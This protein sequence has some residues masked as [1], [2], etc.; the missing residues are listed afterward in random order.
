[1]KV[2]LIDPEDEK[3]VLGELEHDE[4]NDREPMCWGGA[5]GAEFRLNQIKERTYME[6]YQLSQGFFIAVKVA[7]HY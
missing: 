5:W 4:G 1:M 6:L 2:A 7:G 3:S